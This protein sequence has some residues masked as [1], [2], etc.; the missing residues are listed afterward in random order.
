MTEEPRPLLVPLIR[1]AE[2]IDGVIH[3]HQAIAEV[4]DIARGASLDGQAACRA[5]EL[6]VLLQLGALHLEVLGLD[7]VLPEGGL[8]HLGALALR[9]LDALA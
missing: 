5:H 3:I 7:A 1:D 6:E 2:G 9:L 8:E 4:V